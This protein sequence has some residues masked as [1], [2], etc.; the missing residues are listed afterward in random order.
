MSRC[1]SVER[2]SPA[3]TRAGEIR[4]EDVKEDIRSRMNDMLTQQRYIDRLRR[5]T[6]VEVRVK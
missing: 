2:I 6:F 5:A 4:Y 3:G 1:V